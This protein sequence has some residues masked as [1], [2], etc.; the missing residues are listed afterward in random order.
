MKRILEKLNHFFFSN[1][2][3]AVLD[4]AAGCRPVKPDPSNLPYLKAQN[5][6]GRHILIKPSGKIEPFYMLADD[7]S[8][9]LLNRHHRLMDGRW[10][11]GRMVVETSPG[12]FQAWIHSS[13]YLTLDEKRHWLRKL[14]SDPGADPKNRWGR[15]PGFRNRKAKHRDRSG[16]YPLARLIWIDWKYPAVIPCLSPSPLG[17]VC[18]KKHLSRSVYQQGD[19]SK[20]DF[21]YTLALVRSRFTDDEIRTRLLTERK[22]WDNHRGNNRLQHYLNITIQK[23]RRV[24]DL[25]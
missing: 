19:E 20:T 16:G 1:L 9:E 22:N 25:S 10:K 21:A 15:C 5:A 18:Q 14:H 4:E 23:A 13:R 7:L 11:P 12:N 8:Q 24:V 2:R 6:N 17:G 3:L